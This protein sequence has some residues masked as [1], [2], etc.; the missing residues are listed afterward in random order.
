MIITDQIGTNSSTCTIAEYTSHASALANY[1]FKSNG[2]VYI[3]LHVSASSG[4]T[5]PVN[6]NL[7]N[8][9]TGYRPSSDKTVPAMIHHSTADSWNAYPVKIKSNG[10]IQQAWTANVD[11]IMINT[12]Y[13][14]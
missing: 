12:S 10:M 8:V 5:F 6:T 11:Q 9:P 4:Y 14:I 13:L 1:V 3:A 2:I 7:F